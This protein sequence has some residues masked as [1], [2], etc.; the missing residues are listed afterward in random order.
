M[1]AKQIPE[2]ALGN[3]GTR[4]PAGEHNWQIISLRAGAQDTV[5]EYRK[6]RREVHKF[7]ANPG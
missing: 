7:K 6:L 1:K 4:L 5:L 2:G 3:I